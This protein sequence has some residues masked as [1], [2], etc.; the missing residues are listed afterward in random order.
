MP[1]LLLLFFFFFLNNFL[2]FVPF[3]LAI[4]LALLNAKV[5]RIKEIDNI[6]KIYKN[7]AE[8]FIKSLLKVY[9]GRHV[10]IEIVTL[11]L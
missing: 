8:I 10:P 5:G 7:D 11:F 3:N 9:T 2:C 6:K 4:I 1:G